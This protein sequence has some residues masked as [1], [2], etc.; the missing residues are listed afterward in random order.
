MAVCQVP[1]M[2]AENMGVHL[3]PLNCSHRECLVVTG[4]AQAPINSE[5]CKDEGMFVLVQS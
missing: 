2:D 1:E 4:M 5:G 3:H